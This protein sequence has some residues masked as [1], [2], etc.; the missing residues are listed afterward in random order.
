MDE[1]FSI[2]DNALWIG[3]KLKDVSYYVQA[4]FVFYQLSRMAKSHVSEG[5]GN[6]KSHGKRN[7]FK[8]RFRF[9]RWRSRSASSAS[10]TSSMP[11]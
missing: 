11:S 6:A 10:S 4:K 8:L 9:R 2:Y 3:C 7:G 5:M 1:R